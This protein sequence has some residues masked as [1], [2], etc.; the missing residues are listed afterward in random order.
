[1]PIGTSPRDQDPEAAE[2]KLLAV[3]YEPLR[4]RQATV[5]GEQVSWDERVLSSSRSGWPLG[6]LEK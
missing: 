1:M 6:A 3:A 2:P 4:Q 5:S